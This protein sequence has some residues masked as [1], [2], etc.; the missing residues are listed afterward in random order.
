[1]CNTRTLD[2]DADH[3]VA[4]DSGT[5]HMSAWGGPGTT[6]EPVGNVPMLMRIRNL[7]SADMRRLLR[8]WDGAGKISAEAAVKKDDTVLQMGRISTAHPLSAYHNV[9]GSVH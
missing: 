8:F 2:S 3:A 6:G 4:A 9:P 7:T 1:M 5:R